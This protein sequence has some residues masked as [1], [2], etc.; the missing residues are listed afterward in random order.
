[1]GHTA[2]EYVLCA[3]RG[4]EATTCTK[5]EGFL[6]DYRKYVPLDDALF[7]YVLAN[8]TAPDAVQRALMA[9]THELGDSRRMQIAHPQAVFMNFLTRSIGARSAL[10]IGTFTGYSALAIARGLP[11]DGRLIACDV[12]EEWTA[13]AREA[14]AAAGVADRIDLRVGPALETLAALP[15]GTT[16]DLVFIDADKES[17]VDYYESVLPHLDPNGVILADNTLWEGKVTDSSIGDA[18]TRAIRAFNAHVSADERA[19]TVLLPFADGL[20]LIRKRAGSG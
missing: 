8:T 20:T 3:P 11:P 1:M 6:S 16:F 9:R 14:W 18:P 2:T 5:G 19:E 10:E 4:F 17:Y 13:I 12:S 7:D 15:R